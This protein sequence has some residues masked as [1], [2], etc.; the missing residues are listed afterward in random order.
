MRTAPRSS[1]G[2]ALIGGYSN[3]LEYTG[4]Y[5]TYAVPENT[6]QLTDAV[7]WS[8]VATPSNLAAAPS[9]AT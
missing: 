4:D 5:G 3:E 6:Y 9:A 7:S 1:G 8:T 2:G